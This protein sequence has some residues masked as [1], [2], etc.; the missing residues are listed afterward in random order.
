MERELGAMGVQVR[1][2]LTVSSFLKDAIIPTFQVDWKG[3][4]FGISYDNTYST[5]RKAAGM[6]SIEFSLSYVNLHHALFKQRR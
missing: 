5:L 2:S 4:R 3:F 6:S 1:R